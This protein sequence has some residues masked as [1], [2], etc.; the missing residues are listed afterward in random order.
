MLHCLMSLSNLEKRFRYSR[1]IRSEAKGYVFF[2]CM[3][4]DRGGEAATSVLSRAFIELKSYNDALLDA[5]KNL[6][7]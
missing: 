6:E 2:T 7:K 5:L 4:H 1:I 3:G